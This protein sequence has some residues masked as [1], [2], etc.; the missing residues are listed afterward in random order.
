[1]KILIMG[2]PGSGK[3]TL[4]ERLC[5]LLPD[6]IWLN[7]DRIRSAYQDWDFSLEGRIRQAKRMSI[8]AN[9]CDEQYIIM[10]FVC[11]LAEMIDIVNPD[12]IV[13][14][15]TIQESRFNDTNTLFKPPSRYNYRV[16][17]KDSEMWAKML[18]NN[19]IL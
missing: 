11:P 6:S 12:T 18:C 19:F 4:S 14:M 5:E 8:L 1:M 7:A 3:S 17:E 2:L 9:I 13:W 10:D 16:T 15:D